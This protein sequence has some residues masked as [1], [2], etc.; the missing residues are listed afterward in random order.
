MAGSDTVQSVERSLDVLELVARSEGGLGL[1]DLCELTGLKSSTVHN[2]VRTLVLRGYLVKQQKPQR[3]DL[4]PALQGLALEH[5]NRT[6]RRV[7]EVAVRRLGE[8]LPGF[9][10]TLAQ[11]QGG[12]VLAV[13]RLGRE[14]P[15]IVA[16]PRQQVMGPYASASALVYQAFWH[17]E[18][19]ASFR[20]HNPFDE[21]GAALW[22]RPEALEAFLAEVRQRGVVVLPRLADRQVWTRAAVPVFS[23]RGEL[24]GT[25]GAACPHESAAALP[26]A[27]TV[28]AA[29]Q[30]AAREIQAHLTQPP[31]QE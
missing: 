6:L 22:Q 24:L 8:Q 11:A 14:Q 23:P 4:G 30:A 26:S 10:I 13:L 29:L 17:D 9:T 20:R 19:R 31:T 7:E 25:L 28:V 1:Q 21:Y 18:A 16:R 3:Y 27:E 2:L 12:D 15:G 5:E